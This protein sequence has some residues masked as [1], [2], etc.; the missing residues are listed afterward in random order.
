MEGALA[1]TQE[2]LG[3]LESQNAGLEKQVQ[4]LELD[5]NT[6]KASREELQS[7]HQEAL[8]ALEQKLAFQE[9]QTGI[10]A[11]E[12]RDEPSASGAIDGRVKELE[13]RIAQMTVSD[14]AVQETAD[15]PAGFSA[16]KI[17]M[18]ILSAA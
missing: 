8:S 4:A 6:V 9:E 18:I 12:T 1:A 5:Q 17:S 13:A 14:P 16:Q 2:K 10:F 11:A 7:R 15:R 3:A